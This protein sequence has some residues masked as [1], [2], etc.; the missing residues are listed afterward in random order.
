MQRA[1]LGVISLVLMVGGA[2]GAF[3]GLVGDDAKWWG[4][5]SL[6][7]GLILGVLWLVMPKA[8]DVPTPVWVGIGIFAVVLAVR[9]R[10][11]LFGIGLAFA[12]MLGVAIAQRR[13]AR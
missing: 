5:V 11:V 4:G 3:T 12:A 6:R 10:L 7:A 1:M 9:P 13:T 2:L 8:R